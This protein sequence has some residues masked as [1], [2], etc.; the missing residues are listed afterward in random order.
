MHMYVCLSCIC[1]NIYI[2]VSMHIY[3]CIFYIYVCKKILHTHFSYLFLAFSHAKYL[4]ANQKKLSLTCTWDYS[5]L[6]FCE[7]EICSEHKS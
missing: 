5:R 4:D 7:S 2:Y 6:M 3:A 1:V